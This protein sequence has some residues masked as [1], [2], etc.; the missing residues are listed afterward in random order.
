MGQRSSCIARY[1]GGTV[2]KVDDTFTLEEVDPPPDVYSTIWQSSRHNVLAAAH[3]APQHNQQQKSTTTDLE[4]VAFIRPITSNLRP[5][6]SIGV[7][8]MLMTSGSLSESWHCR[9][10]RQGSSS[11]IAFY[12]Q[13]YLGKRTMKVRPSS[14]SSTFK[15]LQRSMAII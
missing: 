6:S 8:S 15:T 3:A 12:R 2:G 14:Y 11:T 13:S 9:S 4:E 5:D 7:R 1:V 10:Q